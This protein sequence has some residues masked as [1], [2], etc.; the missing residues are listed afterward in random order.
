MLFIWLNETDESWLCSGGAKHRTAKL[1][2][3]TENNVGRTWLIS[4]YFFTKAGTPFETDVYMFVID[5]QNQR[6]SPKLRS[7]ALPANSLSQWLIAIL[8]WRNN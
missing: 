6:R 5:P 4:Q 3:Y 2:L 1:Q 8:E 7:M